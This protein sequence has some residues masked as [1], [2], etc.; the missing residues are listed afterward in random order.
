MKK[1]ELSKLA[2]SLTLPKGWKILRVY[3]SEKGGKQISESED[4]YVGQPINEHLSISYTAEQ[5]LI[6]PILAQ[7]NKGIRKGKKKWGEW[8][9]GYGGGEFYEIHIGLEV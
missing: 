5:K 6:K 1:L 8:G 9:G 3:A 2:R 7:L 4:I